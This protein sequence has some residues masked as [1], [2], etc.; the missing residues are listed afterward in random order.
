MFASIINKLASGTQATKKIIDEVT[1]FRAL[2]AEI[3]KA[4]CV[5]EFDAKGTITAINQNALKA[6]GFSESDVLNE[7]HRVLVGSCLLY[8]SRCV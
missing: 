5:L 1:E 7:H 8:T 6:L 3:N 4:R 2:K